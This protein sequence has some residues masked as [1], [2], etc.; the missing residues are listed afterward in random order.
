MEEYKHI[1]FS[2]TLLVFVAI[3]TCIIGLNISLETAEFDK[4]L[5][6]LNGIGS[7]SVTKDG[8]CAN[9]DLAVTFLTLPGDQEE[10]TVCVYKDQIVL[11][12]RNNWNVHV[13]E[14]NV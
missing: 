12:Y 13:L 9:F 11:V 10:M 14:N 7:L 4:E 1:F 5:E 6:S 3:I 8:D 2:Y